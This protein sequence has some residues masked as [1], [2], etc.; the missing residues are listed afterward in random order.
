[1]KKVKRKNLYGEKISR[2]RTNEYKL[3]KYV[4]KWG[5]QTFIRGGGYKHSSEGV[6]TFMRE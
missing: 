1:M 4:K 6:Q 3:G 5:R 2:E